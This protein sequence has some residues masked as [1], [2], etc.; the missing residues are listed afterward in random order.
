MNWRFEPRDTLCCLIPAVLRPAIQGDASG[1]MQ[2]QWQGSNLRPYTS[3]SCLPA[4]CAL[5]SVPPRIYLFWVWGRLLWCLLLT[6][7]HSGSFPVIGVSCGSLMI[8][9]RLALYQ[10]S[11]L[12]AV[13]ASF[14]VFVF[15]SQTP[16]K[17]SVKTRDLIS[18]WS[19]VLLGCH[20]PCVTLRICSPPTRGVFLSC[21]PHVHHLTHHSNHFNK[22]V[23]ML[24]RGLRGPDDTPINQ[25]YEA[26]L[27]SAQI[28]RDCRR[29]S[30]TKAERVRSWAKGTKC[31]S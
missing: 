21:G 18:L 30:K 27:F 7:L 25:A 3:T 11:F 8:K 10:V 17:N 23:I 12:P 13:L 22:T 2:W 4:L 20:W 5:S 28:Q 19:A 26:R 29:G 6:L 1:F 24:K 14:Y 9:L 15:N 16:Q 31:S